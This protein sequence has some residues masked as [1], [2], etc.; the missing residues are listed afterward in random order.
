MS[1]V[2]IYY[3]QYINGMKLFLENGQQ[4]ILGQRKSGDEVAE[5]DFEDEGQFWLGIEG[6]VKDDRVLSMTP[7][8]YDQQCALD[9]KV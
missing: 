7:I 4:I 9:A 6:I 5:W 2:D 3:N 8:V 1:S